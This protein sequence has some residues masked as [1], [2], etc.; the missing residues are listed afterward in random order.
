MVLS[1]GFAVEDLQYLLRHQ[2][3][4]PAGKYQPDPDVL[5]Q[6]VRALAAVIHTIQSQTAQPADPTTFTDDSIRQ[7]IAQVFPA[8]VSQTF[9][10]MWTGAIQYTAAQT[11][12]S[13]A[14]SPSLLSD[15]QNIQLLYDQTTSTQTLIFQGVPVAPAIA[16]ITNE[17]GTLTT[18]GAITAAQQ[19]LL[20]G[21]L[22]DVRAQALA[23]FQAYLQQTVGGPPQAGFLQAG[24]FD[25]LFAPPV[26]SATAR[27][28]L[29]AEFLPYLQG[30]LISQAIVQA[31][32]GRLGTTASLTKTLL[33]NTSVLSDPTQPATSP[34]PLLAAFQA[35]GDDGVTVTYYSDAAESASVGSA[36]VATAST[37]KTTNPNKPA[38]VNSVRFE[39]YIE[40]PVDGPYKFTITLPNNT[41]SAILRF[42]FLTQPLIPA[43][44]GA[45]A[46]SNFAQFKAGVPYHFTLDYLNLGGGD[47]AI[48]VQGETIPRGPLSQLVLYPAA[49]VA[50]Y[51]RAQTL[52]SKTFQ[53]V[54]GFGLDETEIVYLTSYA[55]DFG[56]VSFNAL[57]T[58]AGD[59]SPSKARSLFG[60]FLRLAN[61]ANLRKGPAGGTDGL[62]TIF[63][64]ARQF[65]P[66]TVSQTAQQASQNF[67]QLIANLT[68]RD[69]GTIQAA[70]TQLWGPSAFGTNTVGTGAE[71][72]L[73][74][75]VAPLVNDIGFR[76]LWD[77]LQMVQTLAVQPTVLGQITGIVYPSRA[78]ISTSADPGATV[79]A[80]LRN[81]IKAHYLPDLWRPIAQSVFDPLRQAK[82]DALCAYVLNL[83]GV[84]NFGVTDTNGLFEYFLVDPGME[85]VV[86]T[87]RIRLAISSVQTFIQ[88]CF[89]NL[90]KE[91]K[92]SILDSGQWDWMKRYRVWE[93][94]REIF[95][96]PENW[97][98]PEFRENSTDLFQALQST[99]LQG[100]ITQ[101]LAEQAF[102][103][104]LQDLDTRARLDIV[105]VFN[106]PPAGSDPPGANILHVIG[107]NH[108][109][110]QKYFYRTFSNGIWSGWIPVT[111]DIDGDHIL[112]VIW[113][114]RLNLFW[115]T[116][117]QQA[118][119][120]G[121][122]PSTASGSQNLTSLTFNDFAGL[123]DQG[124]PQKTV[125]IQLNRSEYYQGE[126]A[127]RVSSDLTRFSPITVSDNFDPAKDVYVRASTDTDNDG[128]ETAVRIHL[129]GINQSFRLTS[130]NSEPAFGAYWQQ[131]I[132]Q[133]LGDTQNITPYFMQGYDATKYIGSS[134]V[135]LSSFPQEIS[136]T[137]ATGQF[138]IG[139]SVQE[140][141]LQGVN[142]FEFLPCDNPVVFSSTRIT[143]YSGGAAPGL[144]DTAYTGLIST[145]SSPFFYMDTADPN[146]N[147]ELT[148]FVQP[149]LTEVPV[150]R[151]IGWAIPPIFPNLTILDPTYWS[152][153]VVT[154]Q[155]PIRN[156][157]IPPDLNSIFQY[158]SQTDWLTDDSAALAFGTGVVARTG[159]IDSGGIISGGIKGSGLKI[160][161]SSGFGYGSA[162]S[163]RLS[164]KAGT[165]LTK[166]GLAPNL[167][168]RR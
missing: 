161:S 48:E 141:I 62:I 86:Q 110:P 108:S 9:M 130:K 49:S 90:E 61:Y 105:S 134:P 66:S 45:G 123:V 8:D 39:G 128:N 80:A 101:D 40:F 37:D 87:S 139:N 34:V 5:M 92:P 73:Q 125:Q 50:R 67:C 138:Q 68:R 56:G 156:Q 93:A 81:A 4:D 27:L 155:V 136:I 57:P 157:P 89:L 79:A 42:D 132:N 103:Q 149:N 32:V 74:F 121:S 114:G 60:Q 96:W 145:L 28:K 7:K 137:D 55:T 113:R 51:N 47:A 100:D 1:S 133:R 83:P 91:V 115:L 3:A 12:V 146:S 36:T 94:N 162:A 109:K 6:D 41:A 11:G 120:S 69:P 151:R 35:A 129:D 58:Q 23:F 84:Q 95:L 126:W 142:S 106:Q 20:T 38:N 112:A 148:F 10:A 26:G 144:T 15:K 77:A 116:F 164:A 131:A 152:G 107:R 25:T 166:S 98:I 76:R 59:D 88:R 167:D 78:I 168:V 97:L 29:A 16:A 53:L 22:N 99:L 64:N 111:V 44:G 31:L 158:Q 54:Q 2:I 104:Y 71:A 135:F 14:I 33:T 150:S 70:I 117:A 17:L 147:E 143:P 165:M 153:I 52:L 127:T 72:Q 19:T 160:I 63:E 21:L 102:T 75:T 24:D 119:Q 154:S 46:L 13:S 124:K 18:S 82:R 163:L 140:P 65:I 85:P 118:Q 43:L 159:R 122:T 30:Q